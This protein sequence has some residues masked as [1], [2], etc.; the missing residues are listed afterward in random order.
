MNDCYYEKKDWRLCKQ[1]V[2]YSG[3]NRGRDLSSRR[4]PRSH[5]FRKPL[6]ALILGFRIDGE[7][8]GVLETE[9]E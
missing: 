2:R 1:E 3:R 8:P 4:Q 7:F 5:A 6:E 9:R